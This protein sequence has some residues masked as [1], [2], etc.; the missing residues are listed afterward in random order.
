MTEIEEQL[1]ADGDEERIEAE[2][3][4]HQIFSYSFNESFNGC[5]AQL[6]EMEKYTKLI[7]GEQGQV[8]LATQNFFV[9]VLSS[10]PGLTT[11]LTCRLYLCTRTEVFGLCTEIYVQSMA[12]VDTTAP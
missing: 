9:C 7:V 1:E 4:W 6:E 12:K 5:V 10:I 3:K 8:K 11:S 2:R